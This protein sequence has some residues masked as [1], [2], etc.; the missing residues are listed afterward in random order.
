MQGLIDEYQPVSL[1]EH[2]LVQQ[3][4]MGWLRLHRLWGVEAAIAN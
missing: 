1:T 2:L 3:V 4:A